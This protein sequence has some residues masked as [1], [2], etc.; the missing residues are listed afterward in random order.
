MANRLSFINIA[1][2]ALLAAPAACKRDEPKSTAEVAHERAKDTFDK[3]ADDQKKAKD[4]AEDVAKASRDVA[5]QQ[6]DL[7]EAQQKQNKD[8]AE[9]QKDLAKAEGK[10]AEEGAEAKAAQGAAATSSAAAQATAAD[11]E[12]KSAQE[13]KQAPNGDVQRVSGRGSDTVSGKI[14]ELGSSSLLIDPAGDEGPTKVFID[15]GTRITVGGASR[16]AADLRVGRDATILVHKDNGKTI[17]DSI[18]ASAGQ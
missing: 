18:E 2:A 1:L 15:S 4:E 5:E 6:K 14:T 3:A 8:I 13:M 10:V 12:K 17:A 16:P 7:A 9:Q 11:A